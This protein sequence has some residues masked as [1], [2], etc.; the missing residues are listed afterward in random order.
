MVG[1]EDEATPVDNARAEDLPSTVDGT[2][3]HEGSPRASDALGESAEQGEPPVPLS[4]GPAWA[5]TQASLQPIRGLL[6]EEVPST[7][8]EPGPP[9]SAPPP[10]AG[11]EW[12]REAPKP[13]AASI[14]I[15]VA[16]TALPT[17]TVWAPA[18]AEASV[19]S[20]PPARPPSRGGRL[21]LDLLA[22]VLAVLGGFMALAGAL[23]TEFQSGSVGI[24]LVA[25]GAPVI[26]EAL[27]PSGIYLLLVRW[28]FALR[29]RFHSGLLCAISGAV[30][31]V[32]ESLIYTE[33]YF[34][35]GGENFVLFRFTVTPTMHAVASF[36][37][38]F[39]LSKATLDWAVGKQ[40]LPRATRNFF[41]A[42]VGVHAAYNTSAIVLGAVGLLDFLES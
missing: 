33:L 1:S 4:W 29:S 14:G 27:K 9:P 19:P 36:L 16:A 2:T 18:L 22:L 35:E 37:V 17:T 25:I 3:G 24:I 21:G 8:V 23:V 31:G 5:L 26:E 13:A 7:A 39:G 12:S 15:P 6:A 38:G 41:L 10:P 34:P 28:P 20:A 40:P 30:F 42:G 11:W 32:I